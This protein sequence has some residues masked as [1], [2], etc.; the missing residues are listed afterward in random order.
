M[1]HT[2]A[3]LP[4]PAQTGSA[5]GRNDSQVSATAWFPR[6]RGI[7]TMVEI[8]CKQKIVK[9]NTRGNKVVP[10]SLILVFT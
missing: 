10:F 3:S 9:S 4:V 7:L 5:E 2:G 8:G 1:L 6:F